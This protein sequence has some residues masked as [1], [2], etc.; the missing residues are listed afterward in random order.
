M[1]ESIPDMMRELC[2]ARS[3]IGVVDLRYIHGRFCVM[4]DRGGHMA[5]VPGTT[6]ST[7][8]ESL[9]SALLRWK[10]RG[11]IEGGF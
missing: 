8:L 1:S 6:H 4:V 3:D 2:H 7:A 5:C 10:N 9:R 11:K